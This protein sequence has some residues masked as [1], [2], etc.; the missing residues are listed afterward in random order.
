MLDKYNSTLSVSD[1]RAATVTYGSELHYFVNS[2]RV[3]DT[4]FWKL[5]HL[6]LIL[7]KFSKFLS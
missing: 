2:L 5:F 6:L 3:I 4:V 1:G 7:T